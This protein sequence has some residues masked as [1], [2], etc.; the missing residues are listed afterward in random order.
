[1]NTLDRAALEER[2]Q[3]RLATLDAATLDQLDAMLERLAPAA[4]PTPTPTPMTP[5]PLPAPASGDMP[6]LTRRQ[7]IGALGLGAVALVGSNFVTGQVA[8]QAGD[9]LSAAG[10]E[11]A[12]QAARD[13]AAA[14]VATAQ[15]EAA[16]Q[17]AVAN[18][19]TLRLR[20]LVKL[21]ETLEGVGIDAAIGI[22]L[23]AVAVPFEALKGAA[24]GLR[25]AVATVDAALTRFE[26]AIPTVSRALDTAENNIRWVIDD[27]LRALQGVLQSAT[28]RVEPLTLAL[29]SFFNG[30]IDRIPGSVG[31]RIRD[32][33]GRIRELLGG[34]EGQ[35][36]PIRET[37]LAP[38]RR[39]WFA[40]GDT[41]LQGGLFTPLRQTLLTPL[42][43][44]L[45]NLAGL[46]QTWQTQLVTPVEK[47]LRERDA[48][49]QQ[50]VGYRAE[51]G[52][53]KI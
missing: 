43:S 19:E 3:E 18:V 38:L 50:I 26:A 27:R 14:Q 48:I 15:R 22:G 40:P 33:I 21:Y 39:D 53:E 35:L 23:K 37:L 41:G 7:A 28:D 8:Y 31:D 36:V 10:A 11:A 17:L 29:G 1:M 25:G 13:E 24:Q 44:F 42:A 20:A 12:V 45:D 49:R 4:V 5:P 34:L 9:R 46:A 16:Q 47:A 2:I 30:L 6:V 51:H 32:V 52:L